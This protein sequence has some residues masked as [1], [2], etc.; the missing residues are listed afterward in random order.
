M[1]ENPVCEGYR[2]VHSPYDVKNEECDTVGMK[3]YYI[4]CGPFSE[5]EPLTLCE[6]CFDRMEQNDRMVQADLEQGF[7]PG[8][9]PD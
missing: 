7:M 5:D 4:D 9:Q 3:I 2:D 8:E 6:G 1:S